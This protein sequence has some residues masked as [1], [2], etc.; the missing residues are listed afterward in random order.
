MLAA[1]VFPDVNGI[2]I[3]HPS[4][5]LYELTMGVAKGRINKGAVALELERIARSV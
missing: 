2:G 5:G 4:E 3:D 1:I